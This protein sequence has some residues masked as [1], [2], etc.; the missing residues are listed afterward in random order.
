MTKLQ[1][2]ALVLSLPS[3]L[4]MMNSHWVFNRGRESR[5]DGAKKV[6]RG[7]RWC[8]DMRRRRKPCQSGPFAAARSRIV[9]SR[10]QGARDGQISS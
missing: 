10:L 3:L 8:D 6:F 9:S 7:G 5:N 2:F 1:S 4:P